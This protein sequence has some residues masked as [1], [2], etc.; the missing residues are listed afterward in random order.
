MSSKTSK[1]KNNGS[2]EGYAFI[3]QNSGSEFSFSPH[4]GKAVKS[5]RLVMLTYSGLVVYIQLAM[6]GNSRVIVR[7][8]RSA[9]NAGLSPDWL[10]IHLLPRTPFLCLSKLYATVNSW[11]S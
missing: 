11:Y 6:K 9:Q 7:D 1:W 2:R 10:V 8:G 4:V 5:A 3:P